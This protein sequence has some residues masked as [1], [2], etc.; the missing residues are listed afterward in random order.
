MKDNK[1]EIRDFEEPIEKAK[2]LIGLKQSA[3]KDYTAARLLFLNSQ[4]H[5]AAFFANTCIEKELKSCLYTFG[6]NV[7]VQHN[8]H[9]LLNILRQHDET[10]FNLINSDFLKILTKIYESRYHEGL[11]PGYNF[12]II[13]RKFLAELDYTYQLLERKVRFNIKRLEGDV[14]QS[15]YDISVSNKLPSVVFD[16][17]LYN[18]ISKEQ[19]LKHRDDVY[20]FRMLFNHEVIDASYTIPT[21]S[22]PAQFIYEALI[23]SN[24][25]H[26]FTISNNNPENI[27]NLILTRN[28]ILQSRRDI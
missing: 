21:N 19:Y 11:N 7:T 3:F 8:S 1:D 18:D 22:D 6:L 24:N 28:G 27:T 15:L 12:V 20:E 9:K 5:A 2:K 17:Y 26:S 13:R 14:P 25:N 4:L 16:N 23:P 10:T